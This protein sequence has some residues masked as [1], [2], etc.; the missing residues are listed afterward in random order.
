GQ[1]WVSAG[2]GLTPTTLH[3]TPNVES[4]LSIT[5]TL[6]LISSAIRSRRAVTVSRSAIEGSFQSI[7]GRSSSGSATTRSAGAGLSSRSSATANATGSW[8]G[9]LTAGSSTSSTSQ[10]FFWSAAAGAVAKLAAERVRTSELG[11]GLAGLVFSG[12]GV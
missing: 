3:S 9:A 2:P 1:Y 5:L 12:A 7:S 10:S 4:V 8:R 11:S 6:R